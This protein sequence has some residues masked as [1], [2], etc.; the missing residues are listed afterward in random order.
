MS[1]LPHASFAISPTRTHLQ[2]DS[3]HTIE[4]RTGTPGRTLPDRFCWCCRLVFRI[5]MASVAIVLKLMTRHLAETDR[6][7]FLGG[8]Y[9]LGH[10]KE[11]VL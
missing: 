2:A 4:W 8:S 5:D 11:F 6:G 1:F 7:G 9:G 10:L 3:H